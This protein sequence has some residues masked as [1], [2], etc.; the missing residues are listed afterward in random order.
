MNKKTGPVVKSPR[1]SYLKPILYLVVMEFGAK[2]LISPTNQ[3]F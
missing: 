3:Y 2:P 1:F